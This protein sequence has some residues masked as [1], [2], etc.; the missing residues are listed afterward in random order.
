MNLE[1]NTI[2]EETSSVAQ[3]EGFNFDIGPAQI[4]DPQQ[5]FASTTRSV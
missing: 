2:K 4:G 3:T 1:L 5:F